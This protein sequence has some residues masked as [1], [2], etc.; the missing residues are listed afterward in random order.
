MLNGEFAPDPSFMVVLA[1][2]VHAAD[3][4]HGTSRAIGADQVATAKRRRA[5]IVVEGRD[6]TLGILRE[7]SYASGPVHVYPS[8]EQLLC[9]HPLGVPSVHRNRLGIQH[10]L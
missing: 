8:R 9:V 10:I 6:H 2:H 5:C 4:A 1:D 3:P 7:I